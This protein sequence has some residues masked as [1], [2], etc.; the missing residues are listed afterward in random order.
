MK[1][2]LIPTI[3]RIRSLITSFLTICVL[4]YSYLVPMSVFDP[5]LMAV[6]MPPL[7]VVKFVSM[8]TYK[9]RMNEK[10][11]DP[12]WSMPREYNNIHYKIHKERTSYVGWM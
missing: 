9:K 11:I 1:A 8:D 7:K 3:M 5:Y 2:S 4:E 6:C 12:N 10:C